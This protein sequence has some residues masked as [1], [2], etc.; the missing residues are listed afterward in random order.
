MPKLV[1]FAKPVT[2]VEI[3]LTKFR[4]HLNLPDPGLFYTLMGSVAANMLEGSPCWLMLVGAPGSGKT[5]LLNSLLGIEHVVECADLNNEATFLSGVPARDRAKNATGGL[6]R[7]V[8]DHG[9]IVMND[10]TSLLSKADRISTIMSVF[11]ECF[12]GRWTRHL[13]TDG[14]LEVKWLGKLALFAGVTGAIDSKHA[15]FAELGERWIYYRLPAKLESYAEASM[16]FDNCGEGSV[17]QNRLRGH[18]ID[19]FADLDLSFEKPIPRREITRVE[20]LKLYDLAN[21]GARCRSAITRDGYTH[22]L[23]GLHD[24][25]V[26]TRLATVLAQLLLGMDR[27]GVSETQRW[28]LLGKVTMDCMPRVRK[29]FIEIVAERK[30]ASVEELSVSAGC[31]LSVAKRI[32]EDLEMLGVVLK[33]NGTVRF[34]QWMQ[35]HYPKANTNARIGYV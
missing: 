12:S 33:V 7:Q 11:R 8:G 14:G 4:E 22:D 29:V 2:P 30:G 18:V 34:T 15:L 31:S 3:L 6:L 23:L 13:G 9:G 21:L 27:I 17:W 1:L 25:E 28:R 24:P 20:R 16:A 26:P 10:L 19:F 35:D 32:V 5:E